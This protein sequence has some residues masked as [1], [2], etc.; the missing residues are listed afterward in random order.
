MSAEHFSCWCSFQIDLLWEIETIR[1]AIHQLKGVSFFDRLRETAIAIYDCVYHYNGR[2]V[3]KIRYRK[4]ATA[5]EQEQLKQQYQY[6]LSVLL[7]V[8]N[9]TKELLRVKFGTGVCEVFPVFPTHSMR[10]M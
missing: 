1:K 9:D 5:E 4:E 3:N 2:E 10:L 8:F 7:T 6:L